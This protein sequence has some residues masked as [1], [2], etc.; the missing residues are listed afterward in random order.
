LVIYPPLGALPASTMQT[1][2]SAVKV[3]LE[4]S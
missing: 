4:L 3:A 1:V 2:E